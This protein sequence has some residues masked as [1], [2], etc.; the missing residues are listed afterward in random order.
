L[1]KKILLYALLA[2]TLGYGLQWLIAEGLRKNKKGV[3]EK[4][5]RLFLEKNAYNALILG[6]SRAEMHVDVSLLDSLTGLNTFNA[7]V[8]GATTR[9]AYTVLKSYLVSSEMPKVIFFECDF[10]ISHLK[11]DTIFNFSRYFPY[12]SNPVLYDGFKKIDPRFCQ[13]KY[14]PF[15]SLPYSGINAISPALHGWLGKSGNYD[16]FYK[17]GFFKNTVIDTYDHFNTKTYYGYI[18][19]ETQ[20]YL[21]SIMLFCKTNACKLIFTMSP[22]YKNAQKEVLNK[23]RIIEHYKNIAFIN[24]IPILDYSGD[25]AIIGHKEYFEDN[26]HML[27]R[28]AR[29]YTQKIASDFNNI[30]R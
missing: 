28:G 5:N 12:L 17:N 29:I 14:N 4:Y 27:Y 8:S 13:F 20:Q 1:I 16:D 10:H 11:T 7:G 15:Y 24:H 30:A 23:D 3:Y 25:T 9:M 2:V 26:Y 18:N 22:A 19:K 6:S 21:D